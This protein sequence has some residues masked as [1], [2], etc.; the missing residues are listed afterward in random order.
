MILNLVS[1]RELHDTKQ[2]QCSSDIF[3]LQLSASDNDLIAV[4]LLKV[5]SGSQACDSVRLH[6]GFWP[7]NEAW[8]IGKVKT[9]PVFHVFAMEQ[10]SSSTIPREKRVFYNKSSLT[11]CLSSGAKVRHLLVLIKMNRQNL[12]EVIASYLW[13]QLCSHVMWNESWEGKA[14]PEDCEDLKF[15]HQGYSSETSK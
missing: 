11:R 7:Q 14:R 1:C 2:P 9:W 3:Q 12:F 4:E 15:I 8:L 6:I 10:V 13:L 5:I